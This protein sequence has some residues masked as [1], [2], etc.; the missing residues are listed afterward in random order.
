MSLQ[1][2]I[3]STVTQALD[4]TT[5]EELLTMIRMASQ[6]LDDILEIFDSEFVNELKQDIKEIS[7]TVIE[8]DGKLRDMASNQI[9][10]E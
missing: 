8:A 4:G 9:G 1:K 3:T 10:S 2:L 5:D 7:T 6:E